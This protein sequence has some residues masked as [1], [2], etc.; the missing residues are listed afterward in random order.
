MREAGACSVPR[1]TNLAALKML[2]TLPQSTAQQF[3]TT[4]FI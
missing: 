2:V 4:L 1:V 3:S